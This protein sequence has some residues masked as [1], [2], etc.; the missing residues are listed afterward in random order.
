MSGN[1]SR[2]EYTDPVAILHKA[3]RDGADVVVK[4]V[5]QRMSITERSTALETK[6]KDGDQ[7]T[8]PLIIAAHNGNLVSVKMLLRYKADMEARGTVKVDEEVIVGCTPLWA[9]AKKGHLDIVKIL[10]ERNADVNGRTSSNSTPLR[11]A[12]Y[13]GNLDIVRCLV[14]NGADVNARNKPR[15]HTPLMIA[16]YNG[17]SKVVTCLIESGAN[18]DLQDKEG[19]TA[20]H[21][22]IYKDHFEIVKELVSLGA[23]RLPN[24]QLLTPLLL[25]NNNCKIDMVEYF[26]KRP[27][28]TKEQRVEGLELLGA[29]IANKGRAYDI[30]KAFSYMKRAMEERFQDKS[31]PL[32]KKQ[33]EPLEVY[34]YRKESQTLEE[35]VRLEGDDHAIHM[36][37]LI[38]RQRILGADN[39]ALCLPIRYRGAVFADLENF[40]FCIGLWKH[41]LEIGQRA[42]EPTTEALQDMAGLFGE[43]VHKDVLLR[44]ECVKEVFEKLVTEYERQ[45]QEE[46]KVN[47]HKEEL[48]KLIYCALYLIMIYTKVQIPESKETTGILDCMQRFL[49]LNP[50]T[51]DGNT[52]L[53]LA[54]WYKTETTV[55]NPKNCPMCKPPCVETMKLIMHAGCNVNAMNTKGNS[56]LH[57][58]VTFKPSNED[59][60]LLRDVLE[61]LFDGGVHEDLVN[62]EGKTAMDIAETNEARRILSG[63]RRLRLKCIAARAVRK[64]GLCYVGIVP[65]S[66]ERFISSH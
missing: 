8:T 56:P 43:M 2:S 66:L 24:I 49:R 26:I 36:E 57:L 51:R 37:G 62:S 63:K 15:E 33:R 31:C 60:Q 44:S 55:P 48:E 34:Q 10:I 23:P 12:A 7:F 61:T 18:I 27:E 28:C 9:A 16:C 25:A 21:E 39:T 59:L 58:A 47:L 6:T 42:N 11:A 52:L 50:R 53:H 40:D 32:L 13:S 46:H 17:H 35:L 64:F 20:L 30:E 1:L 65:E 14:E 5:L 22:A 45:T 41:A 29:T 3:A 4:D 38:I 54:S 19:N